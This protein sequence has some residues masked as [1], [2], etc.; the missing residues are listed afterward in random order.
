MSATPALLDTNVASYLIGEK[1]E[2][3]L[4]D[5]ALHG[6]PAAV[7]FQTA[8][9]LLSGADMRGWGARRRKGL[10]EFLRTA[11]ILYPDRAMLQT[12]A[13]LR[14]ALWKQGLVVGTADLWVAATALA[15]DLTLVAHDAVFRQIAGLKLVCH[16]P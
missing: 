8:A 5:H 6:R 15:H 1:P 10:R 14:A 13:H 12:W 11:T 2:A 3:A 7:S 16:A 4:Y 9:E